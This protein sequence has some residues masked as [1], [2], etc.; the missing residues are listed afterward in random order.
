MASSGHP[1][2]KLPALVVRLPRYYLL[3][4][5]LL[6][7]PA[8][9]RR[10]KGILLACAAYS[11]SPV[12]LVPGFVPVAGQL[13]DWAALLTGIRY[14]LDGCGPEAADG[15]LRGAGLTRAVLDEDIRAVRATAAWLARSAARGGLATAALAGRVIRGVA[16]IGL[17]AGRAGVMAGWSRV[18][19]RRGEPQ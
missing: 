12:D 8:V 1:A 15:H 9:D 11:L 5:A 16:K 7:E 19:S 6:G 14:A 2:A 3:T 18:G 4:K 13:D 17:R 10:R